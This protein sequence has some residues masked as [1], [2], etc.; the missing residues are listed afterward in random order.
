MY[1]S[2][3]TDNQIKLC[4]LHC[5][6]NHEPTDLIKGNEHKNMDMYLAHAVKRKENGKEKKNGKQKK[7]KEIKNSENKLSLRI[8]DIQFPKYD[9]DQ[10][11]DYP[12]II[13]ITHKT[14]ITQ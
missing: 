13:I 12:H 4:S 7:K 14:D 8:S 10:N 2:S 9:T 1:I 6:G 5:Y 11:K 3:L